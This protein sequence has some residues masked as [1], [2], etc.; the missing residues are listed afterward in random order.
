VGNTEFLS[1]LENPLVFLEPQFSYKMGEYS[2]LLPSAL[3]A[4]K[5][6][7][8]QIDTICKNTKYTV[9]KQSSIISWDYY[10]GSL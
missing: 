3:H 5:C 1:A 2:F 4:T 7:G 8:D 9:E 10:Q 6:Y